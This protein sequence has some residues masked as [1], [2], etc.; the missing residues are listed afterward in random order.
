M[1]QW[2]RRKERYDLYRNS[3]P[4]SSRQNIAKCRSTITILSIFAPL[5][6]NITNAVT[7]KRDLTFACIGLTF[8]ESC[9][10]FYLCLSKICICTPHPQT[11][12]CICT[13]FTDVS[14]FCFLMF[15][16]RGGPEPQNNKSRTLGEQRIA[17]QYPKVAWTCVDPN[18]DHFQLSTAP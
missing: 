11:T 18:P 15:R 7:T 12:I 4:R 14:R 10:V 3:A 6:G 9:R 5:T 17:S 13:G 1:D 16:K 8:T 2:K